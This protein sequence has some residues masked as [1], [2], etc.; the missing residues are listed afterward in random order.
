MANKFLVG[1]DIGD[2]SLKIVCVRNTGIKREVC[3]LES[4]DIRGMEDDQVSLLIRQALLQQ[5]IKDPTVLLAAPLRTIITRSIEIPSRDPHEIQEIVNLQA[6]RHTPYSR[7][8][9]I[10]DTLI[11]GTV[12]ENYTKVLLVIVPKDIISRHGRILEK[13]GLHLHKVFFA[14]EGLCLAC[15]KILSLETKEDTVAIVHMD[16][17]FTSFMVV[18]K[19]RVLFV[20]GIS[21]GASHLA[22]EKEMYADRFVEELNKSIESY[23]QD[24]AGPTPSLLLLT[25]VV[26]E[27]A[28]WDDLF[29][30]TLH[31]PIKH[32]QYFNYFP[33]SE[34]AKQV[35]ATSN[36]LSF[37]HLVAPVLL[38]EKI[39]I[40][41]ISDERK[42]SQ[43]LNR[44]VRDMI[45]A[46]ALIFMILSIVFGMLALKVYFKREELQA[47][48]KRYQPVKED[49]KNLEMLYTKLQV[50]KGYL[51]TRGNSIECLSQ[52]YRALPPEIRLN[53]IKYEDGVK[54]GIK[55]TSTAMPSVF[56]FVSN[57]EKS[58]RFK[59]VKTRYVTSRKEKDVELADF[60]IAAVIEGGTT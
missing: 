7:A 39:H 56:T 29:T 16:A 18:Q 12:R 3:H 30:D 58:E 5:S 25:G 15:T 54:F 53:E 11:V 4:R 51:S 38:L 57:L 41:L 33:I 23:A 28:A 9:I 27:M 49:A 13:A 1:I 34:K 45:I 50:T 26:G 43:Q 24:E 8:E 35:A 59:N 52:L 48:I 31:M 40:D 32:Q 55:G 21:I 6:S 19:G 44:K 20:R 60:D 36:K 17:S 42:F 2:D 46:T 14:P 47:L 37:F 10:I 22:E